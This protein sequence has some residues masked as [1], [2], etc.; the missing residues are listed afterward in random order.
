MS[1]ASH[2]QV[3]YEVHFAGIFLPSSSPSPTV[4]ETAIASEN[5]SLITETAFNALLSVEAVETEEGSSLHDKE[6]NVD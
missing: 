4:G 5:T 1:I 6:K 3:V 2:L